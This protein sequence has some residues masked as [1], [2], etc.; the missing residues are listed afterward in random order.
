[1]NNTH[2]QTEKFLPDKSLPLDFFLPNAQTLQA[3]AESDNGM[4][5]PTTINTIMAEIESARAEL[6]ST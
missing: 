2:A 3:I 6:K 1:M 4:L 5:T